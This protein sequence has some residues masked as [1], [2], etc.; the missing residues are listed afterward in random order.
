MVDR[1][2]HI[3]TIVKKDGNH[4]QVK[5]IQTSAC[6]SC[7]IKGHCQA[8]ESKEKLIDVYDENAF[9]YKIGEN[10]YLYGST[11]TSMQAVILAFAV[12][13]LIVLFTLFFT[14]W[15]T[16]DELLSAIVSLL[17]LAPYYLLLY[18]FRKQLGRKFVFAVEHYN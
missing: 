1:I 2:K 3:G 11:K 9:S 6:S 15:L 4:L 10:V 13:F 16:Q 14:V 5:I 17:S 18:L 8:T 12:P 7:S